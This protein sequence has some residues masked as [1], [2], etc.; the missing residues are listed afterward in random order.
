VSES[1]AE[2]AKSREREAVEAEREP[3]VEHPVH[4]PGKREHGVGLAGG[5]LGLARY[6]TTSQPAATSV[7]RAVTAVLCRTAE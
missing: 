3:H 1:R 6:R 5:R 2:R 4:E 7:S